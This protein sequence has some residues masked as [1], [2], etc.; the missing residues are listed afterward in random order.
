VSVN[1]ETT[2]TPTVYFQPVV[3]GLPGARLEVPLGGVQTVT[4]ATGLD[5]GDHVIELYR[6]TEGTYGASTFSGFAEG[7]LT[8]APASS[9]R[10]V[11]VVGDSISAG[12]GN[13]GVEPHPDW[14]ANPACHWSAENS[15]WFQTYAAVAGHAL[16]AEVSTVARSGWGMSRDRDGDAAGVLPS[17]YEYAVG[18]QDSTPWGFEPP[19][20]VVVINLGTNDINLGDPG[21]AFETAY[22]DF[23]QHVR[24]RYPDAWVFATIGSM[25]GGADLDVINAHLANVVATLGDD[26]VVTFDLGTQD[27]GENGEIP[28]GCD[29]H[30]SA[31]DHARMAEILRARLQTHLGW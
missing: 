27:L 28:T 23:L 8:G 11:E 5:P 7:T 13:L 6:E 1:L 20:S 18:T 4:L 21:T 9:G 24:S 10:R 19:A 31:A 2:G 25:L 22:V 30:P 3:D 14:V 17:V 12:Y 29:W 26:R 16:G 15:S